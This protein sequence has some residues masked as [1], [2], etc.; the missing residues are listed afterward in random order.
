MADSQ[1][2]S[3]REQQLNNSDRDMGSPSHPSDQ[4][5]GQQVSAGSSGDAGRKQ[6]R[7]AGRDRGQDAG[8]ER[9]A[10]GAGASDEMQKNESVDAAVELSDRGGINPERDDPS[11]YTDRSRDRGV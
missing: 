7:P 3:A 4:R 10:D 6:D 8:I 1:N 11:T 2:K 5:S 9:Q